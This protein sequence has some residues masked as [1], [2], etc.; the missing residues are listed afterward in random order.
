MASRAHGCSLTWHKHHL[1]YPGC[2]G[3]QSSH[4][5]HQNVSSYPASCDRSN[6][7]ALVDHKFSH[8]DGVPQHRSQSCG[9]PLRPTLLA[10]DVFPSSYEKS[11]RIQLHSDNGRTNPQAPT[12]R[13]KSRDG[14]LAAHRSPWSHAKCA[15]AYPCANAWGYAY[16]ASGLPIWPKWH[17]YLETWPWASCDGFPPTA[18]HET[19]TWPSRAWSPHR[20]SRAHHD[21][22]RALNHLKSHPYLPR[23]HAKSRRRPSQ[24]PVS[25][26]QGFLL[27]ELGGWYKARQ[28]DGIAHYGNQP[29]RPKPF[30]QKQHL[31]V[32]NI[33]L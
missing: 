3:W 4:R 33:F 19:C 25:A 7:Y 18:L 21:Q 8:A 22:I 2:S 30:A 6:R 12:W 32:I 28:T 17:G 29:H 23:H 1:E 24:H 27:L 26:W 31:Q 14:G 9:Q 20:Q 5:F 16:Y 11:C 13:W 10:R 15:L